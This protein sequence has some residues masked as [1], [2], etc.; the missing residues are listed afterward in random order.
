MPDIALGLLTKCL[1]SGKMGIGQGQINKKENKN[2]KKAL[3]AGI[4]SM[5]LAVMPAISAFADGESFTD[6]INASVGDNCDFSRLAQAG[7][8]DNNDS[9]VNG[10]QAAWAT[11]EGTD[12]LS[13]TLA[14][15]TLA[16][17]L[18]TSQFKVVC[19]NAGGYEVTVDVSDLEYTVE[20]VVRASIPANTT[21]SASLSGWSP[22]LGCN[23]TD[24]SGGTRLASGATVS[25]LAGV[26]SGTTFIV[27]YG[28]G[29]APAQPAGT[30]VG[31][32][33]YSFTQ[34]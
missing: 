1:C 28:V 12:S 4:V 34:L 16:M 23:G 5:T 7:G 6:T 9:H 31:T 27:G 30:Y 18:G 25:S 8:V 14:G 10:E 26:T 22:V 15:G 13:M 17:D 20:G 29:L 2:M 32:A 11:T 3:V 21:Y 33:E 24:C 19:N